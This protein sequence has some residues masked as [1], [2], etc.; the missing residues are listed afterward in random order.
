MR[1][2]RPERVAELILQELSHIIKRGIPNEPFGLLT[3]THVKMSVDLRYADVSYSIFGSEEEKERS[4]QAL[5][6]ATPLIR[7]LLA[8]RIRLRYV[9]ELRFHYDRSIAH[10][11]RVDEL[12]EEIRKSGASDEKDQ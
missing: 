1:T 7:K 4:T 3:L 6:N 9:P 11:A 5:V 8:Q 12:I 10:S 2:Y